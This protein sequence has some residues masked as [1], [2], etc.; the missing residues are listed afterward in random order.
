MNTCNLN[1]RYSEVARTVYEFLKPDVTKDF[2]IGDIPGLRNRV[3]VLK[4]EGWIVVTKPGNKSNI[5]DTYRMSDDAISKFSGTF[6]KRKM[7][8][9]HHREKR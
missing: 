4:S 7:L 9:T 6:G 2:K 5:P 8:L 1:S 3:R